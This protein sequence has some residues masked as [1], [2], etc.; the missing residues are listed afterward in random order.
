M[1]IA[2]LIL[3]DH[4]EQRRLFA[5]IQEIGPGRPDALVAV[6]GRL[7]DLLDAHAEAEEQYLYPALLA[8][9]KGA[10]DADSAEEET[11]DAIEDHNEI[12]DAGRAVDEQALG[13]PAWFAAVAKLDQVNGDHMAEEE[14]QGLADVRLHF[15]LEERHEMAVRFAGFMHH[16]LEGVEVVDKDPD[17][18]VETGGDTEASAQQ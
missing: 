13:S 5:M 14:R 9:G 4:A 11:E 6:W 10:A 8:R 18:Y 15:G 7:R 16:H 3:D 1:D 17:T 12:R 2:Q